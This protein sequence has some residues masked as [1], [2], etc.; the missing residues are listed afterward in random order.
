MGQAKVRA[1][2]IE[3][4]KATSPKTRNIAMFGA[5]YKDDRDD[6]VSIN[7]STFNEVKPGFTK[8]LYTAVSA[9]TEEG[10]RDVERGG[11]T[12]PEIWQQLREAIVA[13]NFKCFGTN[14][15]PPKSEYKIDVLECMSEIVVIMNEIGRAHV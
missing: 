6:G 4:L 10:L 7:F 14:I 5:F 9:A 2:E 3:Q 11:T 12:V 1:K 13:F 15:R 8:V